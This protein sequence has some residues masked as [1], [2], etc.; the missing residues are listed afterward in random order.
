MGNYMYAKIIK[1]IWEYFLSRKI[2]YEEF[3]EEYDKSQEIGQ[4][5]IY[6]PCKYEGAYLGVDYNIKQ[7]QLL[8][9]HDEKI[10][11]KGKA[12]IKKI[13]NDDKIIKKIRETKHIKTLKE[14]IDP[15]PKKLRNIIF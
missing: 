13:T 6:I 3:A 7:W 8:T 1:Q 4:N 9:L 2:T 5:L 14:K 11:G 15:K 12:T 10:K